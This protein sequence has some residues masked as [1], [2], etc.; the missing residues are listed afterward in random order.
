MTGGPDKEQGTNKPPPTRRVKERSKGDTTCPTTSQNPSHW[1]LSLLSK[2]RA[3]RKGSESEWLAKDNPE[4]NPIIIKP[5]TGSHMAEQVSWVPLPYCS[6]PG[7]P[8][9]IQSLALSAHVSSDNS[10]LSVRQE[11]TFG[12]WKG[13]PFLQ[14]CDIWNSFV[15]SLQFF[16]TFELFQK[17]NFIFKN[18]FSHV[19]HVVLTVASWPAYRFLKRQVRWSGIPIS[20]RIFHSL[21]GLP[22]L[23]IGKKTDLFQSCGH[24]W[25]FQICWHI[26]C[27]TFTASSFRIWNSSTGI[28]SHPLALF[29]VMLS[30]VP[31]RKKSRSRLY[32][33]TL[34]N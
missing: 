32:I 10:F 25:V 22:F 23:G 21:L 12:P 14:Q 28:P 7:W 24:C 34:L 31:N 2:L 18:P 13:S 16:Y 15:L 26:E 8:F 33:V 20:F 11:P 5:K 19:F 1:Y 4:T 29:I 30:K 6:P 3:T 27:S 17:W 9:P